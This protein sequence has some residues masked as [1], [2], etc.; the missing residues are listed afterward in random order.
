[1]LLQNQYLAT[2]GKMI[3][4]LLNTG[5]ENMRNKARDRKFNL[6]FGIGGGRKKKGNCDQTITKIKSLRHKLFGHFL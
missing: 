5:S 1:M 2:V 6:V 4:L 3:L